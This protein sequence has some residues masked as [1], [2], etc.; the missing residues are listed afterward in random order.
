MEITNQN[1]NGSNRNNINAINNDD[2]KLLPKKYEIEQIYNVNGEDTY[3]Y[4][5]VEIDLYNK[6]FIGGYN[7]KKT[8]IQYHHAYIQHPK[9]K[10]EELYNLDNI[11]Q[12][13]T[14]TV[15]TI[16]IQQQ[17]NKTISTE[18]NTNNYIQNKK[19]DKIIKPSGQYIDSI[20][21]NIK[22][23]KLATIIQNK[24]RAFLAKKEIQ[25]IK[26]KRDKELKQKL[27]T[28]KLEKQRLRKEQEL[29]LYKQR[30]P[31]YPY[32]FR[33]ILNDVTKWHK[34]KQSELKL[35]YKPKN[36][37]KEPIKSVAKIKNININF[38]RMNSIDAQKHKFR[39]LEAKKKTPPS[40]YKPN[41]NHKIK[42][43][44]QVKRKELIKEQRK[45]FNNYYNCIKRVY[46]RKNN[47]QKNNRNIFRQNKLNKMKKPKE[48]IMKNGDKIFVDTPTTIKAN[49]LGNLYKDLNTNLIEYNKSRKYFIEFKIKT[50]ES[51]KNEIENSK[52][53]YNVD[54]KIQKNILQL[55]KLMDREIDLLDR[56]RPDHTLYS[57][58]KRI[59]NIYYQ[60]IMLPIFNNES[61]QYNKSDNKTKKL[62]NNIKMHPEYIPKK[63]KTFG[64][65]LKGNKVYFTNNKR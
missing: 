11:Y 49:K 51:I 54:K 16:N 43:D 9:P 62:Y 20:Q 55:F 38:N 32:Q 8:N 18:T 37:N 40:K 44:N 6:P 56:K 15:K 53:W 13:E 57:L 30:N 64:F 19:N 36:I 27:Y 12:R 25:N 65:T 47:I 14:Q 39:M 4:I 24:F 1:K 45:V 5:D 59:T 60:L 3:K 31:K 28:I 34:T 17:T 29:L 2:N 35:K 46:T 50:F 58:R 21:W 63:P 41:N 52:L 33:N 10:R 23:N 7:N 61:C 48:W 22:R 42:H 26:I